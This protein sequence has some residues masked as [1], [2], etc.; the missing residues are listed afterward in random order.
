MEEKNKK[1]ELQSRRDFFKKAAKAAL[2][3]M[4]AIV[5]SHVPLLSQAA[6][7]EEAMGCDYDCTYGCKGSCGR[8]CSY[9]CTNSCRGYCS[10]GCKGSCQ[11][12][13]TGTCSGSCRGYS[14]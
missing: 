5:L 2:P 7:S 4:G 10:G 11:S 14:F 9:D 6:D 13:C 1:E 12:Y 8:A 3:I